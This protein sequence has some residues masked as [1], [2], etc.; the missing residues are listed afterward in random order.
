MR[1]SV[2]RTTSSG[3]QTRGGSVYD[4]RP[5]EPVCHKCIRVDRDRYLA[6]WCAINATGWTVIDIWPDT[7]HGPPGC[8]YGTP[9]RSFITLQLMGIIW[10]VC[11]YIFIYIYLFYTYTYI[12]TYLQ[13][14]I[15]TTTLVHICAHL[16]VDV[17]YVSVSLS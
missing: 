4:K 11:I 2:I 15:Y 13:L 16:Y 12:Y 7:D 17:I 1:V 8:I 5:L 10:Y 9:V 6:N 3:I 14:N